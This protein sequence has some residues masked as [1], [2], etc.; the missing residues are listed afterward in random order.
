MA[1]RVSCPSCSTLLQCPRKR[2]ASQQNVRCTSCGTTFCAQLPGQ[3]APA[4]PSA[5]EWAC[6]ACTLRNPASAS[7]CGA[8][9]Q[10]APWKCVKC[11]RINASTNSAC[12]GC[13]AEGAGRAASESRQTPPPPREP[14][15]Q[16][17]AAATL[18]CRHCTFDNPLSASAC[19]V[20]GAPLDDVCPKCTLRFEP[21]ATA[22]AACGEP[23]GA[24]P[25]QQTRTAPAP[26]PPPPPPPAPR[27]QPS[28]RAVG[29]DA[30]ATGRQ[31]SEE[32]HDRRARHEAEAAATHARVVAFCAAAGDAFVDDAFPPSS[33]SLYLDGRGWRPGA[34][35][36]QHRSARLGT[37]TWLRPR[38]ITFPDARLYRGAAAAHDL[39]AFLMGGILPRLGGGSQ[40]WTIVDDAPSADDIRQQALGDCWLISALALLAER[41]DLL[42]VLLPTKSVNAAGAY[43]VRLCHDGEWVTI[44]LDDCL[45]CV[46]S[47]GGPVVGM[48]AM[49]AFAYATRR[50]L[51]VSLVEKAM[52]KLYGCYEA[53]EEGSTDEA[54][55]TL[56]GYPCE[57]IETRP[58]RRAH[59]GGNDSS[60]G[61]GSS[62]GGRRGGGGG[63]LSDPD[64]LWA[65]LL[66]FHEAGFLLSASVGGSDPGESAAA[67]AMGLLVDHAYSLLRVVSVATPNGR[68]GG[69]ARLVMLRNP[70][71]KLEWRGE[72]SDASPLWTPQLRKSL[73]QRKNAGDDGTFW[74]AYD[75]F[76]D[77]FR[78]IEACRVRPEWAEVRVAGSI[79]DLSL[80][81]SLHASAGSSGGGLGAFT[82]EVLE[83]TQA[84]VSM[85]QRNGRG[86][87][88]H[89][90]TDLLVLILKRDDGEGPCVGGLRVVECSDR[91]LRASVTCETILPVGRYIVMPLSLRP[92]VHRGS[93]HLEYV[94]RIGS[95]K[96]LLCE[97]AYMSGDEVRSA[98]AAY[99]LSR[100]ECHRA[101]DRMAVYSMHDPAGWLTYAENRHAMAKF[102]I[103]LQ[104]DGSFNVLPSRGSLTTYDV[105][106]PGRGMLLQML[107]IG[108]AED[109]ARMVSNTKFTCDMLSQEMHSPLAAGIHAA[110]PLKRQ[111]G[112]DA[113]PLGLSELLS[114][115]G[116]RFM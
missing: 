6:S 25:G 72:W 28:A 50:Q 64:L 43:Q 91:Q 95:A 79:P 32:I 112:D 11:G 97:A 8:C 17:S 53:L 46:Q 73:D 100:G 55:A 45:P 3:P 96:P 42:N 98:L 108:G 102:T 23:L 15:P 65:K 78:S 111:S 38:D 82:L 93:P 20:C 83:T 57:R 49:P 61:G 31:R 70:W 92:R 74:M 67:E 18:R 56:T 60:G 40:G 76:L 62:S 35:S 51:W 34:A 90:M 4:P 59:R 80:E 115:L 12:S 86:D 5:A 75:D 63:E 99:V 19:A 113:I 107:T 87:P 69:H 36:N 16:A 37:L 105:L 41:P 13:R 85:I 114:G 109:G 89:E 54:L 81:H 7:S 30:P 33:K 22:C 116:V 58:A 88:S 101:F 94:L 68:N 9:G 44:L 27:G 39:A 26:H 104:H 110:T 77:Y 24:I 106:M 52:A 1:L 14:V 29:H 48:P 10:A 71:G 21:G 47:V 66:S 2:G 103:E 84:E